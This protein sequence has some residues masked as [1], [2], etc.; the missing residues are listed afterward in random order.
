MRPQDGDLFV[1]ADQHDEAPRRGGHDLLAH[2]GAAVAL[3]EPQLRVHFVGPVEGDVQPLHV[4]QRGERNAELR[5]QL[6]GCLRSGHAADAQPRP[7]ALAQGLDKLRGRPAGPQ[8]EHLTVGH[9][10]QGVFCDAHVQDPR[11]T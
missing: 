7:D 6:R 1:F 2:Q 3:D 10:C 9:H 11:L 8:A 5:R 4:G